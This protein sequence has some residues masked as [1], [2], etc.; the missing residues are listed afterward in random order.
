[1]VKTSRPDTHVLVVDD[2]EDSRETAVDFLK[3]LGFEQVTVVQDGR[4]ALLA[5]EEDP[6]I[7]L[8][9]SDWDMPTVDGLTL[10]KRVRGSPKWSHLPFIIMSS[11]RSVEHEKISAAVEDLVDDYI[12]KPFRLETLSDKLEKTFK[13]SVHG[14]QKIVI[15]AD[16]DPDS[17]DMV[18]E[19]VERFGFKRIETFPDGEAAMNFISSHLT[20]IAMIIS[21]W[22]MPKIKGVE[23]LELCR[24]TKA[25]EEVPFFII[26]SQGSIERMKVMQAA[27]L[28]VDNYLLKPFTRD[29]LK[30]RIDRVFAQKRVE[31]D[32]NAAAEKG[33]Y[34]LERGRAKA[35][36]LSFQKALKLNPDFDMGLS[37]MGD[38]LFRT[39]TAEAAIPFY[40][41]ALAINP[42]RETH[43]VKLSHAYDKKDEF[44]KATGTL[45]T[46]IKNLPPSAV[47]HVE[48]AR[49]YM[50]KQMYRKA[51]DELIEALK[52]DPD[53]MA[54]GMLVIEV[55]R[56]L[57]DDRKKD[58]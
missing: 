10:L 29:D 42:G 12:V 18:K 27:T 56:E 45:V 49:I 46:A 9:L 52:I 58:G 51:Y 28:H 32:V 4:E 53:N 30:D 23:L 8:I 20:D 34:E 19:Y 5:L 35:A 55:K 44:A 40:Q 41:K 47:L 22:E 21:D 24:R 1:M 6:T 57:E 2:N 43:Y 17:R 38:A 13:S 16:D 54:A 3:A 48:L 11:P 36:L 15:I 50:R 37:G 26:T 7:G 14:P 31:R 33:F 39:K 25:L